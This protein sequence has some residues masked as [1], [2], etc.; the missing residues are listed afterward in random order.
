MMPFAVLNRMRSVAGPTFLFSTE[1]KSDFLS[2][3]T[4][5]PLSTI[6]IRHLP[7]AGVALPSVSIDC[8]ASFAPCG[9]SDSEPTGLAVVSGSELRSTGADRG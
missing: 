2:R 1:V 7:R 9:A 5:D 4:E 6:H 8:M 3:C